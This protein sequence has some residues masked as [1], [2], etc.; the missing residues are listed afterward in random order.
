MA[1]HT[2]RDGEEP[3]RADDAGHAGKPGEDERDHGDSHR[4]KAEETHPTGQ[5]PS[6]QGG[7]QARFGL[8]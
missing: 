5:D 7:V 2:E 1:V 8:G 4:Q 6:A 3:E